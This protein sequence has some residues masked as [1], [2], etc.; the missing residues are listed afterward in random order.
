MLTAFFFVWPPRIAHDS[1]FCFLPF[2]ENWIR[3]V[4][5]VRFVLAGL[6]I[7][8]QLDYRY[9]KGLIVFENFMQNFWR[10]CSKIAVFEW[11]TSA[12]L[13]TSSPW[14]IALGWPAVVIRSQEISS[15]QLLYITFMSFIWIRY[16]ITPVRFREDTGLPL[17]AYTNTLSL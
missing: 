9:K 17:Y 7:L 8:T 10:Y 1:S 6:E 12:T 4:D 15:F 11:S 5:K 3:L 14:L 2:G 13:Q 16:A